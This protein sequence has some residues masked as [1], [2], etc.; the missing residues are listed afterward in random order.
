MKI[1]RAIKTKEFANVLKNGEKKRGAIL[2]LYSLKD[3]S[4]AEKL[5]VGV[6]VSK[7]VS[8]SAV[9]RNYIRRLIYAYFREHKGQATRGTLIAIRV[10][11]DINKKSR[12]ALSLEVRDELKDLT[13]KAAIII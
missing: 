6:I 5:S 8:A 13:T 3:L 4:C 9:R 10:V 2:T 7:R 12:K 11:S 1:T